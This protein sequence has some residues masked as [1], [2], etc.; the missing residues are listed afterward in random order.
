MKDRKKPEKFLLPHGMPSDE[1]EF[2]FSSRVPPKALKIKAPYK[3]WHYQLWN[4][5]LSVRKITSCT[6]TSSYPLNTASGGKWVGSTCTTCSR[7]RAIR[8]VLRPFDQVF[9]LR[10]SCSEE[11][12]LGGGCGVLALIAG[13]PCS[14]LSRLS[15]SRKRW[16]SA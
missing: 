7:S 16:F 5:T 10:R 8:S 3:A 11:W 4:R 14:P 13:A 9:G 15:S 1:R 6:T 2:A 12:A